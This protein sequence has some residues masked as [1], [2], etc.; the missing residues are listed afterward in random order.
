MLACELLRHFHLVAV[1]FRFIHKQP[2]SHTLS[3]VRREMIKLI[4]SGN[5]L[6]RCQNG[7]MCAVCEHN[8]MFH[9]TCKDL[10]PLI[11]SYHTILQIMLALLAWPVSTRA[12]Q[13]K[14]AH[15]T[16]ALTSYRIVVWS[17]V[18]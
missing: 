12:Q 17:C 3:L 5:N 8:F 18:C 14:S 6:V 1:R 2:H 11:I 9:L 13:H 15:T 4:K 10:P 7:V 16:I